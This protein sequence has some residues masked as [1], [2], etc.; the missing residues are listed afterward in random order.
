WGDFRIPFLFSTNGRPYLQQ[1]A[2]RSGI[3]FLDARRPT[4]H[5]RALQGWHSPEGLKELL[6]QDQAAAEQTLHEM[7]RRE[8]P[9]RG[10]QG[11]AVEA[12]ESALLQGRRAALVAMATGT[13]KTRTAVALLYRLL[14]AGLFRRVLFLVDR[15]A[16]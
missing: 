7:P 6:A 16:L 11:E 15:T 2:E 8:L 14:K 13:G 3:W 9:L 5:P 4:N 10:Y 12:V 1:V